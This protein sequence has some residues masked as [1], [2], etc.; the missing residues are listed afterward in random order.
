MPLY[1]VNEWMGKHQQLLGD[2]VRRLISEGWWVESTVQRG[3][4]NLGRF[5]AVMSTV[6]EWIPR[7]VFVFVNCSLKQFIVRGHF[8]TQCPEGISMS[9][10]FR[11][12]GSYCHLGDFFFS[13]IGGFM[14]SRNWLMKC[15]M[16]N[17]GVCNCRHWNAYQCTVGTM[18]NSSSLIFLSHYGVVRNLSLIKY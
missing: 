13:L 11:R 9:E 15:F 6:G 4:C 18:W 14:K 2:N 3:I 8:T 17:G 1:Q 12:N 5:P 7:D 10:I 16:T